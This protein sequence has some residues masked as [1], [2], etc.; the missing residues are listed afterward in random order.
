M[1]RSDPLESVVREADEVADDN[2]DSAD[3]CDLISSFGYQAFGPVLVL[4]G[5][6]AMS[7]FGAIPGVPVALGAVIILFAVQI[8]FGRSSP[9]LPG[10]L[11]SI[12][13]EK[14]QIDRS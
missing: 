11:A 9:W 8:L 13:V 10:I 6:L 3:L 12:K 5:L 7:P 4:F 14:S 2:G 1:T